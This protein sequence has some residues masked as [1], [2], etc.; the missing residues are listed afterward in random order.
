MKNIRVIQLMEGRVSQL[1]SDSSNITLETRH[2][3]TALENL[4]E[5]HMF[6]TPAHTI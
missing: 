5:L 1:L 3:R 6:L 4:T 2:I